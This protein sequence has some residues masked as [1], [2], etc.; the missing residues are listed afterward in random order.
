VRLL[1][2]TH[3]LLWAARPSPQLSSRA[4]RLIGDPENELLFSVASVWEVAIKYG[5]ARDDFQVDPRLLRRA[6]LDNGY[7]ELAVT[8]EHAVAVAN[9]PPL[10]RDPFDRILVAQSVVEGITL[11]TSDP[12]VAQYPAPVRKV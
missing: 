2:D 7:R 4:R 12:R 10:H 1:L 3:L 5:R 8:G 6:L 11:L 9:L